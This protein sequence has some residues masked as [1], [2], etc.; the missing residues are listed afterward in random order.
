MTTFTDR[1]WDGRAARFSSTEAYCASC[2]IDENE[3]GK[4]K[5]QDNC[6]LPIREPNGNVNKNAIRAAAGAL[7]GSRGQTVQASAESKKSAARTLVRLMGEA[8]MQAGDGLK[9]LAQ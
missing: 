6:K 3:S 9:K 1:P 5:T 8:K 4:P 7:E 2:L